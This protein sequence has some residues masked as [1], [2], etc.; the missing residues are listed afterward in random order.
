MYRKLEIDF[1]LSDFLEEEIEKFLNHVNNENG[2]SA[3]CFQTE[4]KLMIR[5]SDNLTEE[6]R[7][8]L[9]NYYVWG[10]IFDGQ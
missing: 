3:D 9:L 4:I 1:K 2:L 8:L 5:D 7:Q 6:Q 10:G